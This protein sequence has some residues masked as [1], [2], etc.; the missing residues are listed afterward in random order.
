[1]AHHHWNPEEY[2][3]HAGFVAVNGESLIDLLS[4]RPDERILDLGCGDGRLTVKLVES[5]CAVVGVDASAEQVEAARQHGLDARTVDACRLPFDGEF[6]A[7]LSNAVLHWI[8]DAD[9]VLAGVFRSLR[10]GGRFV[11]EMGGA[12]NVATVRGAIHAELRERGIDPQPLDPW[13]FPTA[14]EYRQRL[15]SAGF[16]VESI[17]HFPRSTVLPTNVAGWLAAFAR[18]FTG[19]VPESERPAFLEA[20]QQRVQPSLQ[21][22]DGAWLL[23]DYFRLRFKAVKPGRAIDVVSE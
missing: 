9:A 15:E 19:A 5:G 12:G 4:P 14:D 3:R 7:V 10:S 17:E 6:D 1:M 18:M 13:Y 21:R 11:A 20:V 22:A 8:K 23:T 16:F 2:A